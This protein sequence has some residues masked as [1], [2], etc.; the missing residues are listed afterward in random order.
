MENFENINTGDI[1]CDIC[2]NECIGPGV[3]YNLDFYP[4]TTTHT[5]GLM[6]QFCGDCYFKPGVFDEFINNHEV[7]EIDRTDKTIIEKPLKWPCIGCKK[8]LGGGHKWKTM[9]FDYIIDFCNDCFP[10]RSKIL[11]NYVKEWDPE[12]IKLTDRGFFVNTKSMTNEHLEKIPGLD[13]IINAPP[14]HILGPL[15]NWVPLDPQYNYEDLIMNLENI[16]DGRVASYCIDNHG[17]TSID[18]ICNSINEYNNYKKEWE[19]FNNNDLENQ[20]EEN[21]NFSYWLRVTKFGLSTYYG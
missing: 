5:D 18:I 9:N 7:E 15:I 21:K 8:M 16:E 17:R 13:C 14:P 11:A 4:F 2:E 10:N 6:V 12:Y 1:S 20:E 3:I 19:T